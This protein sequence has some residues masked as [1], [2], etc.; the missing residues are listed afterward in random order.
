MKAVIIT[1]DK[2]GNLWRWRDKHSKIERLDAEEEITVWNHEKN[3]LSIPFTPEAMAEKIDDWIR[4][5]EEPV[6]TSNKV[7]RSD[8][9]GCVERVHPTEL[10][11]EERY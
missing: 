2:N 5:S 8:G 1:R 4:E 10:A 11:W 3:V 9:L 7:Y 6:R